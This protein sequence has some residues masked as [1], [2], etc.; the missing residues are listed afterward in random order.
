[1]ILI[2]ASSIPSIEGY[3]KNGLSINFDFVRSPGSPDVTITV[4]ATNSGS[5]E[6][7][8]FVFQAAVPKA[9][10]LNLQP[11]SGSTI[12]AFGLGNVSQTMII[13][14]ASRVGGGSVIGVCLLDYQLLE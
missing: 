6:I 14:N 3:N 4:T 12:A 1:M 10:Q 5:S 7:T 2:P 8:D 11:P 9:F 13:K